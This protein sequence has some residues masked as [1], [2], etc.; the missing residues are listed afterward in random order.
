M[1]VKN[2][3]HGLVADTPYTVFNKVMPTSDLSVPN[4]VRFGGD[5]QALITDVYL[6][7]NTVFHWVEHGAVMPVRSETSRVVRLI[8]RTV[9]VWFERKRRFEFCA[10]NYARWNETHDVS[11]NFL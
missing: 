1:G 3:Q 5:F 4:S 10:A 11:L 6:N 7:E 2:N 8:R 9:L